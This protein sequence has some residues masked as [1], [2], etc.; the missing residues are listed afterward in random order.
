MV[1]IN[2]LKI[3]SRKLIY[4]TKWDFN[5]VTVKG[6]IF[7]AVL[8]NLTGELRKKLMPELR[9]GQKWA[10]TLFFEFLEMKTTWNIENAPQYEPLFSSRN[11]L[12]LVPTF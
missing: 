1:L 4:N 3:L 7:T 10:L 6:S 5:T 8:I 11:F 2:V 9:N 12:N